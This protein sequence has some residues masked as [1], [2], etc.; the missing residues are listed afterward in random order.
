MVAQHKV[1]HESAATEKGHGIGGIAVD[2][3]TDYADRAENAWEADAQAKGNDAPHGV[4]DDVRRTLALHEGSQVV[5]D[6]VEAVPPTDG[7]TGVAVAREV[8]RDGGDIREV[9]ANGAPGGTAR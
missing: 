4:A 2:R 6:S 7:T 9:A 8:R 1:R 5:E 3:Q